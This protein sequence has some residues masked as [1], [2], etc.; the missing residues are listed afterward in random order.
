MASDGWPGVGWPKEWGGRGLTP[1]EQ[2]V[3]F[4]ES[5]R[6]GAPVPMLTINS[7]APTIMRYGSEEQKQ[8]YVPKILAGEIHFAIGYTEPDAGTDLASLQDAGRARRRRVRHQRPEGLHEPRERRRLHLARG[9]HQPRSEEAQG[10]LDHHRAHRHAR[11]PRTCRSRT[12]AA[13][14]R[15]SRTTKTCAFPPA[16]SSARRTG[17]EPHHQP[18]QP[19]ARHAV[20]VGRRGAHARRRARGGRRRRSSP[21][22]AASS[23]RSGCR[24]TSARVHAKLEFL[25]LANWQVAWLAQSGA[26]LNPADASTIKVFGTEFYME[27]AR[28]LMEVMRDQA[29]LQ[30]DSPGAVLR[31]PGRAHAALD[32]HPHLRRRHQRDAARPDRDLRA[33][34]ARQPR[35]TTSSRGARR[36]DFALTEEQ[37]ELHGPAARILEDRMGL[38]APQGARP[39]RRLV[40]PRHVGRVRQGEPAR[41]RAARVGRRPRLRLPRPVP[42]AARGRSHRRAAARDPDA[43]RRPRLPIARFG[44]DAQQAMLAEGRRPATCCS[45]PRSSSWAPSRAADDD[46]DARRRRLAHQRREVERAGRARR[47]ARS[48]C[49]ATVGDDVGVFLVPAER[50]GRHARA[51]GD[52]EPRAAVRDAARGR[53]ASATTRVL[54]AIEQGREILAWIAQPHD[55]RD[56]ARSCRVSPS[57]A[58]RIT[59]QYTIDRKQFDRA[60]GTFQ[61]VGQRMADCFIDN[62]AIELTMLQAATHLDEGRDDAVEVATA[63]FWAAEGGNRIGHAALHIHGGISIDLDYP[64]HRYFLWLKQYEFALGSAHAVAPADRQGPRGRARRELSCALGAMRVSRDWRRAACATG[65]GRTAARSSR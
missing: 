55:G 29:P 62:Q 27:A 58:L 18:A 16:T 63:K 10:H 1:I 34:H 5:M 47:R 15:T 40:R 32:A 61:A 20:L 38:A 24:S 25:R 37:E 30:G 19:R 23:T 31:G 4:D 8:F 13:S 21:T 43:R 9:A 33:Q 60:I 57:E 46:G 22:A 17:L 35:V 11:L 59:A 54:G 52:D 45:R 56:R 41:H 6:A 50:A 65:R 3:F 48:S 39:L 12:S 26:P 2:F 64:I 53:A 42:R 14:T 36:M 44:T 49:P 7:V 51:P 28:L